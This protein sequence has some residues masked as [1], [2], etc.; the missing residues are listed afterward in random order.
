MAAI[1]DL[2]NKCGNKSDIK[3]GYALHLWLRIL[4]VTIKP[5][6]KADMNV[7]C[8]LDIGALQGI[9]DSH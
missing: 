6:I 2:L 1:K 5:T 9:I 3:V 8:P 7:G 4:G